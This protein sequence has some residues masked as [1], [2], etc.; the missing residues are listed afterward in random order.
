MDGKVSC[1]ILSQRDNDEVDA[2]SSVPSWL[3]SGGILLSL[4]LL[5]LLSI[6]LILLNSRLDASVNAMN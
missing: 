4:L 5:S 2:V 1:P 6:L 3:D